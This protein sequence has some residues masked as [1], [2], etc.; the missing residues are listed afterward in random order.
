MYNIILLTV[1]CDLDNTVVHY[2]AGRVKP[3]IPRKPVTPKIPVVNGYR[4]PVCKFETPTYIVRI[5]C[6]V[7]V[8]P[9]EQRD[10]F[11]RDNARAGDVRDEKER[12]IIKLLL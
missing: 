10:H 1:D 3:T 12:K 5:K 6:S 7:V 9:R 2:F 4:I 8:V 11:D